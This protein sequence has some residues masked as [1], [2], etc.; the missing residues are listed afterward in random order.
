M[1]LIHYIYLLINCLMKRSVLSVTVV[2]VYIMS[3]DV[4][5]RIHR[6]KQ[7]VDQAF[8]SIVANFEKGGNEDYPTPP[9][10]YHEWS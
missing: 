1:R 3:E 2:E 9:S 7:Y 10:Y 4:L 8:D 5:A 6:G